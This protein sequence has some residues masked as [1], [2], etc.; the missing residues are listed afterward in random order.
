VALAVFGSGQ[1]PN[2]DWMPAQLARLNEAAAPHAACELPVIASLRLLVAAAAEQ[3]KRAKLSDEAWRQ[4]LQNDVSP[5]A[6][7]AAH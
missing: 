6:K 3:D 7:A 4:L 2:P 5:P 1:A